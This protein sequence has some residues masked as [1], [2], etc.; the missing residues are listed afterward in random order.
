MTG[1]SGVRR[2]AIGIGIVLVVVGGLSPALGTENGTSRPCTEFDEGKDGLC[3]YAASQIARFGHQRF[4]RAGL[5]EARDDTDVTHCFLDVEVTLNPNTVSGS[6]TL[7]VTSRIDGLTDF[8][9]DLFDDMTVDGVW[10]NGGV[11]SYARPTDQIL[12]TL[13]G[14][15]N[16]GESFEVK[17]VYHG[18][19]YILS[20]EAGYSGTHGSPPKEIVSTHSQP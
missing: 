9:L 5:R 16:R 20:P 7:S 18:A 15:Y 14:V 8:T 13:D 2:C 6:N 11:A 3:G 1:R 4:F 10:V 12:V 17:V 19:P